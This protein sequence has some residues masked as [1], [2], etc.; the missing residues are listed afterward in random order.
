LEWTTEALVTP[1]SPDFET[2]VVAAGPALGVSR[3]FF[4]VRV[5]MP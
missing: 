4:R 1:M 5:A 3:A 2:V